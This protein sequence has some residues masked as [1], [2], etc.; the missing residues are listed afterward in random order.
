VA[1]AA[2]LGACA[3]LP[4]SGAV[5]E[6]TPTP[7]SALSAPLAPTPVELPAQ[8]LD[9]GTVTAGAPITVAGEG[10]AVL[11]FVR[12]G[13][14]G[15][16]AR[17]DCTTCSG[18]VALTDTLGG[19]LGTGDTPLTGTY[20]VDRLDEDDTRRSVVLDTEGPWSVELLAWDDL[21]VVTGPQQ[22]SGATVIRIG[23]VAR[24]VQ[25]AY[26]PADAED[27]LSARGVPEV[28]LA[29][30]GTPGAVAFGADSAV[31][32][33]MTITLP[34]VVALSTEGAWSLTPLG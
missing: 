18:P 20:L 31:D 6:P 28:D 33:A 29:T 7:T 4:G 11:D 15:V 9:A 23:D 5:D 22:G 2:L 34:G 3:S 26:T 12:G 24:S 1:T 32:Q 17:V 16:V 21:P 8:R 19:S 25:L 14:F 30:V 10:P 13:A 27:T